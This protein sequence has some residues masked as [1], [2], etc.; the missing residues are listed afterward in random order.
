LEIE[1]VEQRLK[2]GCY[3]LCLEHQMKCERL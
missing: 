3:Q 2:G 1:F